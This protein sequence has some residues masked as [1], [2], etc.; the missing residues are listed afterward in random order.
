MSER[1]IFAG[2]R[3]RRI[4]NER[5][6]TQTAM[7][8]ALGISPS[9]LNL[10]ERNQ[11]PLTVQLILKLTAVYQL[12]ISQLQGESGSVVSAL[13][14]VFS[15]PLL[16]G[17]LPGDQELI[18]IGEAAPNAA[19]GVIKL[20][21]AYNEQR[22]R[23]SDLSDMLAQDGRPMSLAAT[24]LP[25]DEVQDVL[26]RH[27]YYYA[28]LEEEAEA[29]LKLLNA[30]DDLQGA[31]RNW[32]RNEHG[33]AVRT[34]P[35][36][37]MPDWRRR[38][39]RHS[40]RLFISERL[41][42]TDQLQEIACEAVMLR[43]QVAI[44]AETEAL[45]L[46]SREARRIMAQ[47]LAR[48]AARALMMPYR[49]FR[50]TAQRVHY[51]IDLLAARFRVSFQQAASRLVSLQKTGASV[52]SFFLMEIDHAGNI[53]R[54]IGAQGFPYSHFGGQCPKLGLY[55]SFAH[56]GQVLA[57]VVEMPD[58]SRYLTISR[59]V[60]GMQAG[61]DERP[62]RTALLLGVAMPEGEGVIYRR[63]IASDTVLMIGKA[64]RLC[65]RQGCIA[66][67]EPPLTRPL[68]LDESVSGLSVFDFQ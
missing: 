16:S 21:R 54:R 5:G 25:F 45:S 15:D 11:R 20:Y 63:G 12:D 60:E 8:E 19:L 67:A 64:C 46:S 58:Q 29:F 4:R 68:A 10:I 37:T 40:Q 35:V 55:S 48:Y 14:E 27:P 47:E 39:D 52:L 1:K 17:E 13:K 57:D 42:L 49:N 65:E 51:D 32:L 24:R 61:F 28:S 7:A 38:Y 43:M 30:G 18:E 44:A 9:Y 22:Q 34:L 26:A 50:E 53:F 41:P 56:H 3:I 23:L 36:T 59:T 33:I 62:R 2:P 31:L 66:R 6:L